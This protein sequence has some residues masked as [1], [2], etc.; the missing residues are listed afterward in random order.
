MKSKFNVLTGAALFSIITLS[1]F[2]QHAPVRTGSNSS[3]APLP[4]NRP[5]DFVRV[6]NYTTD[7]SQPSRSAL[8]ASHIGGPVADQRVIVKSTDKASRPVVASV[9]TTPRGE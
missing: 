1:A 3:R 4:G 9:S 5:N 7:G 6:V 8:V 2:A